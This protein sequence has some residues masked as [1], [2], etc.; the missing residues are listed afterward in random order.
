MI[1]YLV[2]NNINGKVYVGLTTRTLV[3]R[4]NI[5]KQTFKL[6][7]KAKYKIYQAFAK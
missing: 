2:T 5:H 6:G 4:K 3:Y 7:K 1:I